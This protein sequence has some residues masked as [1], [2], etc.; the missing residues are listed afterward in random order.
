MGELF[1][2]ILLLIIKTQ[3]DE[4]VEVDE[5]NTLPLLQRYD[6]HILLIY[7]NDELDDMSIIQVILLRLV[8]DEILVFELRLH[9]DDESDEL[10]ADEIDEVEVVEVDETLL[11]YEQ[12][13]ND[14][15][16]ELVEEGLDD[17]VDEVE[18]VDV[19]LVLMIEVA[20][21]VDLKRYSFEM[22]RICE[23]VEVVEI[24]AERGDE[25]SVDVDD[26]VDDDDLHIII[27]IIMVDEMGLVDWFELDIEQIEVVE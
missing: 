16:D 10:V 13:E 8:I 19:M 21:E 18:G 6:V 1:D 11:D 26:E 5:L 12:N 14:I 2:E 4:V 24:A 23:V 25:H 15:I 20:D 9:Y 27:V 22:N 17:E 3:V 7:D